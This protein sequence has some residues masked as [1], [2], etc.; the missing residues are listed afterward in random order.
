MPSKTRANWLFTNIWCYLF[1]AYFN[2]KI[3]LLQQTVAW[4][5][6]ILKEGLENASLKVENKRKLSKKERKQIGCWS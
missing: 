6:Y 2:W 3:G 5:Y 1:V 4:V